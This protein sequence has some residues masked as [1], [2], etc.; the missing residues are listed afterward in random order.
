[1]GMRPMPPA[2]RDG[3]VVVTKRKLWLLPAGGAVA[4]GQGVAVCGWLVFVIRRRARKHGRANGGR[5][6]SCKN[7]TLFVYRKLKQG[8]SCGWGDYVGAQ[9]LGLVRWQRKAFAVV[10][11]GGAGAVG[12]NMV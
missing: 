5:S 6:D 10:A 9:C 7:G 8:T 2:Q 12:R 1:M 11:K 4:G 3:E